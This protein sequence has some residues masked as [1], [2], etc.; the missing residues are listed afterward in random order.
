MASP[1]AFEIGMRVKVRGTET[2]TV[3]YIGE[4][5]FA[6][7]M[8]VGIVMD[9]M[10][11]GKNDGSVDGVR[12][13]S[14]PPGRGVFVRFQMVRKAPLEN[15]PVAKMRVMQLNVRGWTSAHGHSNVRE[16]A[17]MIKRVDADV[18]TLCEVHDRDTVQ[19]D[20]VG[21][22]MLGVNVLDYLAEQTGL[23]HHAFHSDGSQFGNAIMSLFPFAVP[24]VAHEIR[25]GS[26]LVIGDIQWHREYEPLCIG[27][28]RLHHTS[29][30]LRLEQLD[31]VF[32]AMSGAN[33]AHVLLGTLNALRKED[34]SELEW[35]ALEEDYM[36]HVFGDFQANPQ[37]DVLAKLEGASYNDAYLKCGRGPMS[38]YRWRDVRY[39]YAMS[40]A[41]F[42]HK[43][44]LCRRVDS[45]ASDHFALFV[46]IKLTGGGAAD[47]N[48]SLGGSSTPAPSKVPIAS[49]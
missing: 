27:A 7:G 17:E 24:P 2:G 43:I 40:S 14:C 21:Q 9:E 4:T 35:Q 30:A 20:A 45:D 8:W 13:F 31:A 23:I 6:R 10:Y 41:D 15:A 18:V 44:R 28:V 46:D 37:G 11:E 42:S 22:K 48:S 12:Y 1:G 34:Y 19:S 49:P 36:Y 38:T 39:D 3:V 47:T 25:S 16:V 33:P 32:T 26:V 5:R 29:E